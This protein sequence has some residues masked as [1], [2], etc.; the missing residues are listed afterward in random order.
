MPEEFDALFDEIHRQHERE[1][2][3]LCAVAEEFERKLDELIFLP[4]GQTP[5]RVQIAKAKY[6]LQE[7]WQEWRKSLL[8]HHDF[9]RRHRCLQ[10]VYQAAYDRLHLLERLARPQQ[11]LLLEHYNPSS[12]MKSSIA[13]EQVDVRGVR[14]GLF[15]GEKLDGE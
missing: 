11:D 2:L 9:G 15:F 10:E 4:I 13:E 6:L 14:R 12:G 3:A 7:E 5:T 8:P 1:L